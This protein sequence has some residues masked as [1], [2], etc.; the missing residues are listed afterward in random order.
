MKF[1]FRRTIDRRVMNQWLE[2][3][4]IAFRLE[5]SEEQDAIIVG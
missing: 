1:S 5:F 4:Q 3:V 2:V